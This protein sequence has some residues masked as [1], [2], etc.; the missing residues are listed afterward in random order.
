MTFNLGEAENAGAS[1]DNM[2]DFAEFGVIP[3][4]MRFAMNAETNNPTVNRIKDFILSGKVNDVAT[5]DRNSGALTL[6]PGNSKVNAVLS[7]GLFGSGPSIEFNYDSNRGLDPMSPG[8]TAEDA[9]SQALLEYELQEKAD[10][11]NNINEGNVVELGLQAFAS[12]NSPVPVNPK[13]I[14]TDPSSPYLPGKS[15]YK[16]LFV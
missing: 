11:I 12:P 10:I 6:H 8:S 14:P 7:P 15:P 4:G 3:E 16:G 13:D 2:K 5:I 9:I 1:F